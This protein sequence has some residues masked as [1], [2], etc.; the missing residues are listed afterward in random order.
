MPWTDRGL[1]YGPP[2]LQ[3]RWRHRRRPDRSPAHAR[4]ALHDA[5]EC[6]LCGQRKL[7]A[8]GLVK[9]SISVKTNWQ[10]KFLNAAYNWQFV[11]ND[12]SKGVHN[13]P[14]ATALLKASMADLTG[15]ANNDGLPDSW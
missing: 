15:D 2:G 8:D 9:S 11:N 1:Q 5:P 14:F 12:G 4:S 10:T 6:R 13:A 3:R 7:V